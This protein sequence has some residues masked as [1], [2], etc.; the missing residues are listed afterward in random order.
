MAKKR[1]QIAVHR[2]SFP[3]DEYDKIVA[4]EAIKQEIAAKS[5]RLFTRM[6]EID[7]ACTDNHNQSMQELFY[8]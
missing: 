3:V 6:M 8:I 7:F 4:E 1:T 5:C 2:S